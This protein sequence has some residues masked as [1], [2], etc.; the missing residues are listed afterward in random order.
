CDVA[1]PIENCATCGG[2]GPTCLTCTENLRIYTN[3]GGDV[4][5]ECSTVIEDENCYDCTRV[6]YDPTVSVSPSPTTSPSPTVTL[7][8]L[9]SFVDERCVGYEYIDFEGT[10]ELSCTECEVGYSTTGFSCEDGTPSIYADNCA[11]N[12]CHTNAACL[13]TAEGYDCNR[14]EHFVGDG[15]D[16]APCAVGSVY[17]SEGDLKEYTCD[18]YVEGFGVFGDGSFCHECYE[19]TGKENCARCSSGVYTLCISG[20]EMVEVEEGFICDFNECLG[21]SPCGAYENGVDLGSCT[22]TK[23]SY[24]CDCDDFYFWNDTL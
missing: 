15:T 8:A 3:S 17:Y 6:E 7:S 23:G 16:C 9:C 4:S 12:D 13:R 20:Y 19:L 14:Q 24:I 22:N 11:V 1:T 2:V 21:N 18:G 5:C 10:P